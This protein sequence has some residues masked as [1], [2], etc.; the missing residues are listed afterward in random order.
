MTISQNTL[1]ALAGYART[2]AAAY[3]EGG[4]QS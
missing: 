3:A 1:Q 2:A 4:A